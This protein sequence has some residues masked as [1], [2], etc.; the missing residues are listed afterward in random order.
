M[1]LP[2]AMGVGKLDQYCTRLL[3]FFMLTRETYRFNELKR[4]IKDMGL[5]MTTPTLILH[6]NHLVEKKLIL[7]DEKEKQF[8]TYRFYWE[9]WQDADRSMRE[10]IVF[11]K[12]LKQ[13]MNDFSRRP[14]MQQVAYVNLVS[15]TLFLLSLREAIVAKV[16]PDKEFMA[17]INFIH[18]GNIFNQTR[19]MILKNVETKDERYA[20][21]CILTIDRLLEHYYEGIQESRK[22]FEK[23]E[24][25]TIDITQKTNELLEKI[26]S[27]LNENKEPENWLLESDI[28]KVVLEEYSKKL[29][30]N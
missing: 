15:S 14:M 13:E 17:N 20:T 29:R 6:L 21:E 18:F 27:S 26:K 22:D 10:R 28:I 16:K 12:V 25:P 3:A 9:K 11:E 30:I 19:N 7:R 23:R 8:V 1:S 4:Q 2:L 5:K 24:I